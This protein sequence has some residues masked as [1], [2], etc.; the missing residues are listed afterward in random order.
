MADIWTFVDSELKR[1]PKFIKD[2]EHRKV[3]IINLI[4]G[5]A[6]TVRMLIQKE[7]I[8]PDEIKTMLGDFLLPLHFIEHER[9]DLIL[10]T[11]AWFLDIIKAATE[12]AVQCEEYEIAANLNNFKSEWLT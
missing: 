8:P 3:H 4:G 12:L 11:C 9:K 10:P 2:I 6:L 1:H 5:S 7:V